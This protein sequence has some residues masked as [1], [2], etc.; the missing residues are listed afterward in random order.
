MAGKSQS[1]SSMASRERRFYSRMAWALVALVFIGFAPSFYLKPLGLSYPRPNPT[2]IPNLMLHGTLFTAWVLIFLAQ[3]S[4]VSAGRRDQHR[5]LGVIGFARGLAMIPV[6]YVTAV[7]QVVRASQ[8]PFT[9][10]L[11][12]TVVPLVGIPVFAVML[13]LGWRTTRRDLQ[14]HKRLMLGLMI[15]LT[16]PAIARLPLAPPLLIGFSV[17]SS[18]SLL[19]FVPLFIWDLRSRGALHWASKLGAALYALV[20][21]AQIFFLATPGIWSAFAKHLPGVSG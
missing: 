12:W 13:W 18:L 2:L 8:P 20:V 14:A 4:L 11:T 19:L 21:V 1:Y 10:P 7:W 16:Q 17:L 15:M 9:D 5:A 3:V 6:M